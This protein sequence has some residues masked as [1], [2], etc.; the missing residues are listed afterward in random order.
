MPLPLFPL[1]VGGG[2]GVWNGLVNAFN[3]VSV[4]I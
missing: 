4:K 2:I 1:V 3:S